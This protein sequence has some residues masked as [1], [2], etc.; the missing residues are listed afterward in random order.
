MKRTF[1]TENFRKDKLFAAWIG[2]LTE[3]HTQAITDEF[4]ELIDGVADILKI[5]KD[6]MELKIEEAGR[7]FTIPITAEIQAHSLTTD[8]IFIIV[9]RKNENWFAVD[10]I[11]IGSIVDAGGGQVHLTINP[12]H[13]KR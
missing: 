12:L 5:S 11:S 3:L 4:D 7:S 13:H 2:Y 1:T 8:K 10:V 9:G 6:F